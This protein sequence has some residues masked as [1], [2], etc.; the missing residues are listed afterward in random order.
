MLYEDSWS[1]RLLKRVYCSNVAVL[2]SQ[3]NKSMHGGLTVLEFEN[4]ILYIS[5]L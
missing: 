1:Y 5:I 2:R 4:G 3:D